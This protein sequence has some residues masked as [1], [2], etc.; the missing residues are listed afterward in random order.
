MGVM[1]I[2]N[3]AKPILII[4]NTISCSL[5]IAF[6]VLGSWIAFD[7]TAMM[8]MF[9][10]QDSFGNESNEKDM[11]HKMK[12]KD[13]EKV[14]GDNIGSVNGSLAAVFIPL[15]IVGILIV[16][17]N[18]V[19]CVGAY[20]ELKRLLKPYLIFVNVVMFIEIGGLVL[21]VFEWDSL[22]DGIKGVFES[23]LTLYG[24]NCEI[25]RFWDNY[26]SKEEC[27]G[28]NNGADFLH[29]AQLNKSEILPRFC[30][31]NSDDDKVEDCTV[32]QANKDEQPGCIIEFFDDH[33]TMFRFDIAILSTEIFL[34]VLGAIATCII[35]RY[36]DKGGKKYWDWKI[37]SKARNPSSLI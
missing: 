28:V 19:G 20:K 17:Q 6:T 9:L 7:F 14:I 12:C 35:L 27:C 13:D 29:G 30:C 5:G 10:N 21:S 22:L 26:M 16:L 25:R 2:A 36:V 24:T 31:K 11:K 3:L 15:I 1:N 23:R 32:F 37:N 34:K 8:S 4:T 18:I 33:L